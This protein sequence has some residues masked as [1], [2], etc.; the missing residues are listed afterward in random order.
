MRTNQILTILST[1]LL[2][3]AAHAYDIEMNGIYYNI[4]SD[5]TV[6]VTYVEQEDGNADFY[7]GDI[8]IP[9]RI[10]KDGTTYTVTA[11]GDNAF[12]Y[13][14]NMTSVTLPP[15]VTSIGIRA[16]AGCVALIS[17]VSEIPAPFAFGS[18]AVYPIST[19]CVLY[20]PSGTRN[21]YIA[22]G[23]TEKVFKGGVVEPV[24]AP[25][26]AFTDPVVKSLCV[27]N[28][29]TNRDGE[30]D[31]DEAAAVTS[32]GTV[33]KGNTAITSFDELQY[34]T[35]LT[36]I[37]NQAFYGCTNLASVTI[38]E[39]VTSL[40][41]ESFRNC[42]ALTTITI[43][44]GVTSIGERAFNSCKTLTSVTIPA[45]VTSIGVRAFAGCVALESVTT[46][47]PVPFAFGG[48]AFYTI[49]AN[50]VLYVPSGTR[51]DYI[52]AG[53]TESVFKGGVVDPTA[54]EGISFADAAVK[55]VC[56]A[57]W[58][59][60][61]D[62]ELDEDEA[63]A[64]TSLGTVFKGNTAIT[65]FDELQY[66]T[67][68]TAIA[69]Q[70]FYGCTSLASVTI[71]ENVTSLGTESF[72]NCFALTTF[73]IPESVTSI[74]ERAFNS[75]KTLESVT[76][77][78][79]VTSIGIRAFAGC[80]ALT[81]VVSEIPTPFAFGDYAFYTIHANC[82][83]YVPVGTRGDY[84]A[85]G[86]TERVFKGGVVEMGQNI[87]FANNTTGVGDVRDNVAVRHRVYTLRGVYVGDNVHL[88]S[89]PKGIYIIDGKKAV[90]K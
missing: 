17:V 42:F 20:V 22:A 3:I 32:L 30:L 45:N 40:G 69:N 13:C 90:V 56:V 25:L 46:E 87:N 2:S 48:Y 77:P 37:S 10:S 21:D 51:N 8:T 4:T 23:W 65:S 33:F 28:W 62:G 83:L 66:F 39:N 9:R 41:T 31:E 72:R 18:Y 15:S 57:N 76:L 26:I 86:W 74:G 16:F 89:L 52:A 43:P 79:S 19:N 38:P 70:T 67:G 35:G 11:I 73:T 47:I 84:I 12:Y 50:C 88:R 34:F 58:D 53:W 85:S 27:A 60:N 6:E 59:T 7:Y 81:S 54:V 78:A 5:N 1:L 49:S 75:C 71:P 14:Y 44:S 55:A 24:T 80:V 36:A 68:L 61:H 29:D 82:V 63:A 64:V